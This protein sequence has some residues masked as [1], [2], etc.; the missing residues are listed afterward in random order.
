MNEF[1]CISP[2]TNRLIAVLLALSVSGAPAM[3]RSMEKECSRLLDTDQYGRYFHGI[4][5]YG[6]WL[7][8]YDIIYGDEKPKTDPEIRV[9]VPEL[10]SESNRWLTYRVAYAACT[11][12]LAHGFPFDRIYLSSEGEDLSR[13]FH[14]EWSSS[15]NYW[16]LRMPWGKEYRVILRSKQYGGP[17]WED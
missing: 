10:G 7:D 16:I 13:D 17:H 3:A 12:F 6:D 14:V 2:M 11:A 15:N 4:L 1:H 8:A 5:S 9:R